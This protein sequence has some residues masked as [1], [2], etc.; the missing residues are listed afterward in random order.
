MREREREEGEEKGSALFSESDQGSSKRV[1]LPDLQENNA[2]CDYIRRTLKKKKQKKQW[3]RKNEEKKT[4]TL[5]GDRPLPLSTRTT[6]AVCANMDHTL[7]YTTIWIII[8]F[9]SISTEYNYLYNYLQLLVLSPQHIL[10]PCNLL[11]LPPIIDADHL[12]ILRTY[13]Y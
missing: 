13:Y 3:R 4:K 6:A 11:D 5:F 9:Y 1:R 8:L 7:L 2:F 12:G 10:T